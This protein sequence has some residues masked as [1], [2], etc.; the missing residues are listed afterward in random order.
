VAVEVDLVVP[1]ARE[2]AVGAGDEAGGAEPTRGPG[3]DPVLPAARP[4]RASP[5]RPFDP[6]GTV[7]LTGGTGTLGRLVARHLVAAHGVRSLLLVSRRGMAAVGVDDLVAELEGAGATVAVAT[8]DVADRAALAATIRGL[9]A[10]RP[11][12]AV[13]HLAGV[14]DDGVIGA[15]TPERI[16]AVWAPKAAGAWHLHEL[17]RELGLD[18][19]AFVVFSSTA[20]TLGAAGQAN[21]AA[22]STFLDALAE[23]RHGAGLPAL[24]LAWGLWDEASGLT[25]GVDEVARARLRRTG[26]LPLATGDALAL[27]DRAL[28]ASMTPGPAPAPA[29]TALAVDLAGLREAAREAAAP[30]VWRGLAGAG[31]VDRVPGAG[32][33]TGAG[34]WTGAPGSG[35]DERTGLAS[36]L[37]GLAP[38][39]RRRVLADLVRAEAASVLGYPGP[40]AVAPDRPFKDLGFDSLT[41]VELRNRLG[42]LA[43]TALPTTLVFD[44]PT[45]EALV[46]ALDHRLAPGAASPE[47]EA[48]RRLAELEAALAALPPGGEAAG[49][50]RAG[51]QRALSRLGSAAAS[52]GTPPAEV[53][54]DVEAE[55]AAA[56]AAELL[57]LID[58]EFGPAGGPEP[59]AGP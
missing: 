23:H 9:P 2:A 58:R 20:G 49:E 59:E 3:A 52:S 33:G 19:S 18:L 45:V 32:A 50:V 46:R 35:G 41:A 12:R 51:L 27:L 6:E 57:D 11:L 31:H 22:A 5:A 8:C 40:E 15:L 43:G 28:D 39:E 42:A 44:H 56:G 17:T 16:G 14:L 1:A 25:G 37:V 13:V 48:R 34:S 55:L 24:S 10:G 26:V 36:R 54:A 7:L 53:A 38:A 4:V 47:D 30:A 29:L 21:Y